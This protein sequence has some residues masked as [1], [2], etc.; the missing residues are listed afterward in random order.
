M[1]ITIS[2]S[3]G[4]ILRTV[5]CPENMEFIQAQ[6]DEVAIEGTFDSE[7]HFIDTTLMVSVMKPPRPFGDVEFDIPTRSWVPIQRTKAELTAAAMAKRSQ[8]FAQCD[9]T[10]LPDVPLATKTAWVAYRQALRDI[11]DQSNFP[12][13]IIWPNSP[14]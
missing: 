9:W 1:K 13:N 14:T 7:T 10:Q 2:N 5:E 3:I 4:A 8:L 11:T 12:N 6:A